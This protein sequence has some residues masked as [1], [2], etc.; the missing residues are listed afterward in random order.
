MAE[1][2]SLLLQN[3]IAGNWSTPWGSISETDEEIK[4]LVDTHGCLTNHCFR[5]ESQVADKFASLSDGA[6]E[7]CIFTQYIALPRQIRG[8]LNT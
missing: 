8:F 5:E 2:D 3:C 1:T 4:N 6:D 7:I